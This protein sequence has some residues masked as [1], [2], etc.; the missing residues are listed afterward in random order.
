MTLLREAIFQNGLS[1]E[2][3][4][5]TKEMLR[6]VMAAARHAH[7]SFS[8]IMSFR[9]FATALATV[10][11]PETMIVDRDIERLVSTLLKHA[12]MLQE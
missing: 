1:H 9:D 5:K 8:D 12:T 11:I 6:T 10:S 7:R 4:A 3:A 2:E